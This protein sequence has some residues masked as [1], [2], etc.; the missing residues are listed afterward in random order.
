MVSN[1][2][3]MI[4]NIRKQL[5]LTHPRFDPSIA[6]KFPEIKDALIKILKGKEK[7]ELSSFGYC[8]KVKSSNFHFLIIDPTTYHPREEPLDPIHHPITKQLLQK[9][10]NNDPNIKIIILNVIGKE[11]VKDKL[12][13]IP[14]LNKVYFMKD[15]VLE[16]VGA[17]QDVNVTIDK[18]VD[19]TNLGAKVDCNFPTVVEVLKMLSE[20][21]TE[22]EYYNTRLV[23]PENIHVNFAHPDVDIHLPQKIKITF[24]NKTSNDPWYIPLRVFPH[25]KKKIID[26]IKKEGLCLDER[27]VYVDSTSKW[28]I[29]RGKITKIFYKV[30]KEEAHPIFS[31]IHLSNFKE[32]LPFTKEDLNDLEVAQIILKQLLL[33]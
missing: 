17:P 4:D 2:I 24:K 30:K 9:L 23:L 16:D 5:G 10:Q 15:K 29:Y 19:I 27:I 32:P 26:L 6:E 3:E 25:I 33:Q 12:I 28:D 21:D 8:I 7:F 31:D 11:L 20:K 1:G 14:F 18:G 22:I 13:Y